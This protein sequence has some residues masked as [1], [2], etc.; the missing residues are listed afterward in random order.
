MGRLHFLVSLPFCFLKRI[1]Q[2]CR[3]LFGDVVVVSQF[4]PINLSQLFVG[5]QSLTFS[6]KKLSSHSRLDL[7]QNGY[8]LLENTLVLFGKK[9][10]FLK[11]S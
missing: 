8:I 3:R 10:Y 7:K 2:L 6:Y 1:T 4:F 11:Y 5:Q 9:C